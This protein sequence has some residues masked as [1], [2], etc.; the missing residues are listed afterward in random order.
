MAIKTVV[1]KLKGALLRSFSIIVR[2]SIPLLL[3]VVLRLGRHLDDL[4]LVITSGSV[5]RPATR[6]A[7]HSNHRATLREWSH[8]RLIMRLARPMRYA[9]TL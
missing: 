3:T 5:R 8:A 6:S 4:Y 2:E 7:L 1:L 9:S